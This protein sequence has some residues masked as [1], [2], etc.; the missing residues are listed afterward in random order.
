MKRVIATLITLAMV[1]ALVPM[2]A[3]AEIV[4]RETNTIVGGWDYQLVN[5]E[6]AAI[7]DT[8]S[9]VKG[10]GSLKLSLTQDTADGYIWARTTASVVQ[11]K[12]Y[13]LKFDVKMKNAGKNTNVLFDWDRRISLVPTGRSYD[14]TTY[15]FS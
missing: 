14:W 10:K 8:S 3:S 7:V 13:K 15:E 5:A 6:A 2:S 1:L 11:G 12:T 9:G 4:D